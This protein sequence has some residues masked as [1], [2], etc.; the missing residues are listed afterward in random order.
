MGTAPFADVSPA[1]APAEP[2]VTQGWPSTGLAWTALVLVTLATMMNFFDVAVF[3]LMAESIKR[4]YALNDYQLGLLLGPA[5]IFFYVIVGI[6]LA[7]LVDIYPRNIVLGIGILVT[8]GMTAVGGLAQSFVQFFA[9]RSFV[10]VGGSAHAPGTY[11]ILSDYFPPKR[12]PRA[13]AFLQLGFILGV[14]LG[15]YL[16][17]KML[18][19]VRGW[20]PTQLGPLVIR[21]WQWVLIATGAVGLLVALSL[22]L[23][24]EPPRRGKVTK[25]RSLPIRD[26]LREI[27]ARRLVYFPLFFGLAISSLEVGGLQAWRVPFMIRT[28]GWTPEQI[29]VWTGLIV[30]IAFPL[31]AV[32]GTWLTE[33]LSKRFKDAPVRTT[34]VVFGMCV[35]FSILAPL[36]PTGELSLVMGALAGVFGFAAAVPQNVA[37][38]TITPNEMRGQVTAIYLFMFTV[39]GALGASL[40][41]P[42]TMHIAGG[43]QNLWISLTL[44]AAGL[45]PLAV[46]AISLGMK[47]YARE[48]E[49]LEAE[50][51]S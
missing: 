1:E 33:H 32:L 12:L 46:Y 9:S 24:P 22:F 6:P 16:G 47:P 25:G 13:F 21:D 50:R 38:Q 23:L 5:G 27:W 49:R 7:R 26:V 34:A 40:V 51:V 48:L 15:G 2:I 42:V 18:G 28:Y 39:F 4:D 45:L 3:Q 41:P 19:Y 37:I 44:I 36:M 35:P 17:G 30:F 8:S 10:G 14:G 11:S 29:G 31:G 20:E 43:E